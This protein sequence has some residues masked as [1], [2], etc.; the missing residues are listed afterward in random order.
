MKILSCFRVDGGTFNFEYLIIRI[1]FLVENAINQRVSTG[2]LLDGP[3]DGFFHVRNAEENALAI[4]AFN[5]LAHLAFNFSV[6][7][8]D[9]REIDQAI[10]TRA[11]GESDNEQYDEYEKLFHTKIPPEIILQMILSLPLSAVSMEG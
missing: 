3:I 11:E 6:L 2:L 1:Y 7:G 8:A 10:G 4:G 5:T 9:D